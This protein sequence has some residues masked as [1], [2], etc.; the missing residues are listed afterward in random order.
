MD[1]VHDGNSVSIIFDS[2]SAEPTVDTR[3]RVSVWAEASNEHN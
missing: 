2:M 1:S 3:C